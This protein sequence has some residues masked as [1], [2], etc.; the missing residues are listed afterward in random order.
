[1]AGSGAVG[2]QS[3][4]ERGEVGRTRPSNGRKRPTELVSESLL[5]TRTNVVLQR[6]RVHGGERRTVTSEGSA[7]TTARCPLPTATTQGAPDR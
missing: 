7:L 2:W 3:A 4:V 1:M 5:K 6:I